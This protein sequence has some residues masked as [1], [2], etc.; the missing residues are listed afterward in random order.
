LP[1][2]RLSVEDDRDRLDPRRDEIVL[3]IEDDLAFARIVRDLARKRGFK[4]LI[5]GSGS[6][7]LALARR[8]RPTGI[9]L[10]VGLPDMDGWQVMEQLKRYGETRHIPVHFMSALESGK[11][12]LDMG[13]VGFMTKP[14]SAEQVFQAFERI[15][16]FA[17]PGKRRLLLVDDDPAT[18]KAVMALLARE[19][20]EAVEAGS[21]EDALARLAAGEVFDCM[22]LDLGLP[23]IGGLELLKRCAE[24]QL[25]LPPVVVYSGRDLS[26]AENLALREFT[27]SIVIKGVR[28]PERL[29]D[30]V[31]L[32]LHAVRDQLSEGRQ[33]AAAARDKEGGAVFNGETVLVVD[34]DMRNAFALS[35]VLRNWGLKVLMAQDGRIA[36]DRLAETGQSGA[37]RVDLVLMDIMMPGMDGYECMGEIRKQP[38]FAKLPVIALT[39][40]AMVGDREKCLAS[41]ADEYVSKPVAT[42]LLLE[43]IKALL[44]A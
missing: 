28:S 37:G 33:K 8:Y 22:I 25:G 18:R 44:P 23:G 6:A 26:D 34:D 39:A 43:K 20:V 27:D 13:A 15:R 11:R 9:V 16:H 10:D 19:P 2:A 30:E 14:V 1:A 42:D 31:T 35:K 21:G 41:G 5:A 7:G 40:K 32:F 24:Q 12:G 36:L 38:Q 29:L 17:G 3:V 4:C